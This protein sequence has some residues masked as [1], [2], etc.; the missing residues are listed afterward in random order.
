[1]KDKTKK[2]VSILGL[3]IFAT[4]LNSTES[5]DIND[6]IPNINNVGDISSDYTDEARE[7]SGMIQQDATKGN[8]TT[9][10]RGQINDKLLDVVIYNDSYDGISHHKRS[11]TT[12][13]IEKGDVGGIRLATPATDLALASA[14]QEKKYKEE[15]NILLA[16]QKLEN[17][18]PVSYYVGGYCTVNTP[19]KI[20]RN[21]E[22][23][24]LNCLL[25]FGNG[26]YRDADVFSGVYPNY[27]EESLT[28]LP[29]YATFPNQSKVNL[30][31]VVLT[32]DKASL[33]IADHVENFRIRKLV[34]E[35]GLATNDVAFRYANAYLTQVIASRS[36]TNVDYIS[37]PDPANPA[38]NSVVPVVTSNTQPPSS[39]DYFALAGIELLSQIVSIGAKNMLEDSDP[40]FRIFKGKRVYLEGVVTVDNKGLG[41]KFGRIA[42]EQKNSIQKQNDN[43]N[44]G[45]EELIRKYE[46]SAEGAKGNINTLQNNLPNRGS[47][48]YPSTPYPY[49]NTSYPTTRAIQ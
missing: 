17:E 9:D 49:Q 19:V 46:Q 20:V 37:V 42:E 5:V 26:E 35:Y 6:T 36:T 4:I 2:I 47:S 10:E 16:E 43:Y 25:D 8:K 30:D 21:S 33:N 11:R 31:G 41:R 7:A 48:P 23:T 44:Q 40:L 1:M 34:A 29:I 32:S 22:F 13:P 14:E 12:Q 38:L 24:S 39:T 18:K 28:V 3:A 45:R 15:Q 27:K